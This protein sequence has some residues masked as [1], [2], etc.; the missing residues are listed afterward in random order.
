MHS[1]SPLQ[2]SPA[3]VLSRL[4]VFLYGSGARLA[5]ASLR[6]HVPASVASGAIHAPVGREVWYSSN[7]DQYFELCRAAYSNDD[8]NYVEGAS[9]AN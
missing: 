1:P 7:L 6:Q 5:M 9:Q 2:T 8:Y 4:R 3:A